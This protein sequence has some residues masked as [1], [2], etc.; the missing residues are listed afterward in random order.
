[1]PRRISRKISSLTPL[2][3]AEA[4]KNTLDQDVIFLPG[5]CPGPDSRLD[6]RLFKLRGCAG[7]KAEA[8]PTLHQKVR[9]SLAGLLGARVVQG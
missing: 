1:M 5:V 2:E 4:Q 3:K 6:M 7:E 8:T 9:V